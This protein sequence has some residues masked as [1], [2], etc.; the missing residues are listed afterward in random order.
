MFDY[1]EFGWSE[2]TKWPKGQI[3]TRHPAPPP[4]P[5]A[6]PQNKPDT[7]S[8]AIQPGVEYPS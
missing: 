7:S 4:P 5:T 1:T 6:R 8:H 3:K 2:T